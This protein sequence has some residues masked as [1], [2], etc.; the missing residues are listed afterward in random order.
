[1]VTG[2]AHSEVVTVPDTFNPYVEWLGIE[3]VACPPDY[4]ALLG[5]KRFES[6]KQIVATAAGTQL[7]KVR[8]VRPGGRL[9]EWQRVIDELAA[10][11]N[12]L[13]DPA[14]KTAYDKALRERPVVG[15]SSNAA[16][17]KQGRTQDRPTSDSKVA[18]QGSAGAQH[19]AA[20]EVGRWQAGWRRCRERQS[21]RRSH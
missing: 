7:A 16:G 8:A 10:A 3:R 18:G 11:K 12:C 9:A 6:E 5:I 21:R 20:G 4:Y 1:M 13:C 19:I 15:G 17:P 14:A 2:Q